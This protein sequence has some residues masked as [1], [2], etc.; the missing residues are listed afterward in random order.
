MGMRCSEIKVL[1]AACERAS[2][3]QALCHRIDGGT[4]MVP[5]K[6]LN[7]ADRPLV[8]LTGLWEGQTKNEK[9]YYS[10]YL[11]ESAK[12]LIF[13]AKE[14]DDPDWIVY[15]TGRSQERTPLIKFGELYEQETREKQERY[16]SGCWGS[17]RLLVFT[18]TLRSKENEPTHVL[19]LA[20][21]DPP[22][23]PRTPAPGEQQQA[24]QADQQR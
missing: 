9:P 23:R 8:R 20:P 7:D 15:V 6:H 4:N 18:N 22:R 12:L 17:A 2:N 1:A 21:F 14:E 19:Y 24:V 3:V 13:Q 16:L 10:G 11:S 5:V